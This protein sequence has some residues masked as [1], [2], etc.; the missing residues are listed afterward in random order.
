[1]AV[2]VVAGL[3]GWL[4]WPSVPAAAPRTRQYLGFTAGLLT[5]GQGVAGQPAAE[6]WA[7]M[8]DASLAT[9]AKVQFLPVP[10]TADARPYLASLVQRQCAVVVAAG[11]GPIGAVAADAGR[12]PTV[13]FVTVGAASAIGNVTAVDA[14]SGAHLGERIGE[15]LLRSVRAAGGC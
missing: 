1:L 4:L 5:D 9:R 14:G 2:A 6:V 12:Y 8:Q 11:V 10:A 15:L 7:G 13:R 3:A